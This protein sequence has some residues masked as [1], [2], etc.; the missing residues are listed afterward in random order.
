MKF[1]LPQP[2]LQAIDDD[3]WI[4]KEKYEIEFYVGRRLYKL[5]SAPGATTDGLSKPLCLR[6]IPLLGFWLGYKLAPRELPAG[7]AHDQ[8]YEAEL[9]PR[10]E[11][12]TAFLWL[13]WKN[14]V[15]FVRRRL[16]YRAVRVGGGETWDRHTPRTIA[17]SRNYNNLYKW[18]SGQWIEVEPPARN[19]NN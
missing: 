18:K 12:D 10:K 11:C 5:I 2:V 14:I 13:L 9:L 15:W 4:L 1:P 17:A 19:I 7:W 6:M 16:Y 3:L 8:I